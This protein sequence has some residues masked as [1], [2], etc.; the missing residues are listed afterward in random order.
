MVLLAGDEHRSPLEIKDTNRRG[1]RDL[2]HLGVEEHSLAR[3][4]EG[5]RWGGKRTSAGR[6]RRGNHGNHKK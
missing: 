4:E 3:R 6:D 1:F 2:Y 5:K